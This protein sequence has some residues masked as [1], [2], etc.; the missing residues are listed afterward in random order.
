MTVPILLLDPDSPRKRRVLGL[1]EMLEAKCIGRKRFVITMPDRRWHF[2]VATDADAAM[3]V[4]CIL[5]ATC[6]SIQPLCS[7]LILTK[8]HTVECR[9]PITRHGLTNLLL[10]QCMAKQV[11]ACLVQSFHVSTGFNC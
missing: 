1:G 8:L 11:T 3:W 9:Q 2:K 5:E 4:A 7:S 6:E 10:R